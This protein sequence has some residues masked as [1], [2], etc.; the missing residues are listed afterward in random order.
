MVLTSELLP[1]WLL[2]RLGGSPEMACTW[3]Q[4]AHGCALQ[5]I[6]SFQ[7]PHTLTKDRIAWV[8]F[9]PQIQASASK[10][11]IVFFASLPL[12]LASFTKL[13]AD[14]G[15]NPADLKVSPVP[16]MLSRSPPTQKKAG[17][18]FHFQSGSMVGTLL[19]HLQ[20][21]REDEI[22]L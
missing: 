16:Q 13:L 20:D 3:P 15:M 9:T 12:S 14:S 17:L 1:R 7:Q 11:D 19:L 21:E 2:I 10:T 4:P 6:G 8:D 5:F 22:K 18:E